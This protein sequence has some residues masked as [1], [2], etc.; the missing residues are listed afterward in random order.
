MGHRQTEQNLRNWAKKAGIKK[1]VTGYVG[2][3]SFACLLLT[4]G[5]NLKSVADALGHTNIKTTLK[6]LNHVE[7]LKD[8]AINNIPDIE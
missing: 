4:N 6:Y 5:A 2:R 7:K 3:H 8:N 1:K